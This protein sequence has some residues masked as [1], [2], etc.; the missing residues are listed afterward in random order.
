[1]LYDINSLKMIIFYFY[2]NLISSER[3]DTPDGWVR[4]VFHK[5]LD[6]EIPG[7]RIQG[8]RPMLHVDIGHLIR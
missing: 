7:S 8:L 3:D 2:I 4:C 5:Y 6:E 1:M